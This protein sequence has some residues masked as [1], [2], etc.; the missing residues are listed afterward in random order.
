[1]IPVEQTPTSIA[2]HP[3]SAPTRSAVA[4]AV[5]KPSVPVQALAP[6]EFST[7]ARSRPVVSTS[8]LHSTGAAL[9]LLRVKTPAAAWAGPSLT[10][11]ATSGRPLGLSPAVAPAARKPC[12]PV[13]PAAGDGEL[14]RSRGDTDSLARSLIALPR[15]A[16]SAL[17]EGAVTLIRSHARSWRHRRH[18]QAHGLGQPERQVHA[19]HGAACGAL[20]EVVEGGDGNQAPRVQVDGDLHVDGVRAE[21]GGGRR[22]DALGEQVHERLVR[23]GLRVCL[24]DL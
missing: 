11:R 7:T 23:V 4:C 16:R 5:W 12:G 17:R 14:A 18:R 22:P 9:T 20:G 15:C 1:M 10:T 2:P 3:I 21:G 19:L 8:W 24:D 13:T 6:P